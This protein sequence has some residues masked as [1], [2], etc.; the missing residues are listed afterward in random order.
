MEMQPSW[1]TYNILYNFVRTESFL[2]LGKGPTQLM[3]A[4]IEMEGETINTCVGYSSEDT[5]KV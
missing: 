2:M 1:L 3:T 4:P 5:F